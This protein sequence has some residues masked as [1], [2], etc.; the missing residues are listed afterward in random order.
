MLVDIPMAGACASLDQKQRVQKCLFPEGLLCHPQQGI[1]NE[2]NGGL[3]NQLEAF[4][5][6]KISLVRPRRFE[7][8]TYSFGGCRSIQLSYGRTLHIRITC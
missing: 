1:L 6:G 8:L 7:L 3:F 5:G 2:H 4:V